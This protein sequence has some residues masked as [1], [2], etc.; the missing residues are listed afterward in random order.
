MKQ[1]QL[2]EGR[3]LNAFGNLNQCG[4]SSSLVKDYDRRDIRKKKLRIKEFDGYYIGNQ[5]YG[6]Y[7]KIVDNSI[8]GYANI[9]FIDFEKGTSFSKKML[10]FM[11][12]GN[13][14]LPNT[15][16]KGD[17][18]FKH[19][20]SIIHFIK[21]GKTR[22]IKCSVQNFDG[23]ADFECNIELYDGNQESMVIATQFEKKKEFIYNQKI[24]CLRAKGE[25]RIGGRRL[26]FYPQESFAYYEWSRGVLPHK[27]KWYFSNM[28]CSTNGKKIGFNLSSD[29]GNNPNITSNMVYY[30]GISY[31]INNV[32]FE[33]SLNEK[34]KEDIMGEWKIHSNDGVVNISFKPLI[35]VKN[36][37]FIS[38]K[39]DKVYGYVN[40]I[41][42]INNKEII[43]NDFIGCCDIYKTNY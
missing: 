29:I 21:D 22:I 3:L 11:P 8:V 5:R 43:I 28:T 30:D 15:S 2:T 34:G 14:K 10:R 20:N 23:V 16:K 13:L 4:Y 38:E 25:A 9:S 12:N 19:K 7:V 18:I 37:I 32:I 17:C 42:K 40:G 35:N 36:N 26:F 1:I 41:I 33:L 39:N 24:N 27:N 31:K 6:F